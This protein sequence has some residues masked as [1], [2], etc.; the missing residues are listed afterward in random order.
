MII[1]I[2]ARGG[3]KRVLNK[4]IIQLHGKPLICH[5]LDT[6][7]EMGLDIPVYVSTDS[8]QIADIVLEYSKVNVIMRPTKI[9]TDSATTEDVLLHVLETIGFEVDWVITLPPTSPFRRATT[10]C[11]FINEVG[12]SSKKIDCLMS[13]TEN[14]GDFW[15]FN[16]EKK[17]TR[18]NPEAPRRQ[19]ER[20]PLYEENSAIYIN[21][22]TS[23]AKYQSIIGGCILPK[24]IS[25]IEAFDINTNEDLNMAK[26]I[27]EKLEKNEL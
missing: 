2:P 13:V 22:V 8:K 27:A 17:F 4:N 3:S 15:H 16:N 26:I 7:E 20:N 12:S 11:E 18:L 25:N 23:L 9:S 19:Q 24:I 21:R 5:T 1:V 6:I 10:I 14:R